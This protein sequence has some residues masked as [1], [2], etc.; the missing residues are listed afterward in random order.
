MAAE[1]HSAFLGGQRYRERPPAPALRALVASV[2][3]Q[4]IGRD[5]APHT[6]RRVPSGAVEVACRIGAAPRVIGPLT[7]PLVEV[8]EPGAVVI[9]MRF[10]PGGFAAVAGQ[11]VSEVVGH[12]VGA[13][14]LWGP[15]AAA[16]GDAIAAAPSPTAALIALQRFVF[17]RIADSPDALV[18]AAVRDLMPWRAAEVTSLSAKL[19]LSETQLRRRFRAAV[20]H[21]PKT[22]HRMLR[23]QGF[24]ALAQRAIAQGRG[25]A[26]DG[27]ALLALRS[28]Y[29]DQPHLTR[30]CVRLTGVPPRVFLAQTRR[31]CASGHDHS[32]SLAPLLPAAARY[33]GRP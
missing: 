29:A 25:P 18:S 11:P 20:G 4:R 19:H 15:E 6:H 31:T 7:E 17:D 3:V 27:L 14:A 1:A 9:G 30:E 26:D 8:V 32:A 21:S 22:L 28:G 5:A 33:S 24:L 10:V 13:E 2:W 12:A 16:L 23:F